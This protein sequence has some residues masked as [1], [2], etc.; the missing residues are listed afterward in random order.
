MFLRF[1]CFLCLRFEDL[2]EGVT[3]LHSGVNGIRL[4]FLGGKLRVLTENSAQSWEVVTSSVNPY[5]WY[6][7]E[8]SWD[9]M[10]GL[11]MYLDEKLEAE[12]S[13]PRGR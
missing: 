6:F 12:D 4:A 3:Y 2:G 5:T 11:K 7:M 1:L 13:N 8:I 10:F 9:E